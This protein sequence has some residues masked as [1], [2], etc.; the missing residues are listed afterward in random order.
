MGRHTLTSRR[1]IICEL[2]VRAAG[3]VARFITENWDFH[4][5]W[6][7]YRSPG[8]FTP[9]QVRRRLRALRRADT[10]VAFWLFEHAYP[11]RLRVPPPIGSITLSS[12][13]RGPMQSCYLGYKMDAGYV[14]RG[15]MREALEQV[16]RFAYDELGL[17][18]IEANVMP[19]NEASLSLVRSLGFQE[20]GLARRYLH[21][22]GRWEDHLHMVLLREQWESRI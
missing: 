12:I 17:H 14:R 4:R 21:I 22:Q 20:E 9:R 11:P 8:Y 5:R 1:L 10:H 6:E 7:P 3:P 15:Y 2:P 18:R 19:D 16:I 13:I